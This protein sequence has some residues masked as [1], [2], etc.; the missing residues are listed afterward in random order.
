MALPWRARVFL[1]T[2]ALAAGAVLMVW[3]AAAA[4]SVAGA[5][6]GFSSRDLLALGE[7]LG[8]SVL[9]QYFHVHITPK[10]KVQLAS[11]VYFAV[12]LLYGVPLA[13]V[14]TACS[15]LIGQTVLVLRGQRGLPG[16]IFNTSQFTLAVA[17]AGLA[18]VTTPPPWSIILSAVVLYV[19]NTG[20][21]ITMAALHI[22]ANPLELWAIGRR[23]HIFHEAGLLLIGWIVA[24]TATIDLWVPLVMTIPAGIIHMSLKRHAMLVEQTV[25]A[26]EAL[27]DIVD[28]RDHYTFE[29]SKRVAGFA[30]KIARAMRLSGSEIEVIRSAARVHDLGK[31]GVPDTVLR[32]QGSLTEEEWEQMRVHSEVGYEILSRFPE[33][34][35]GRELVRSHHERWDGTGYPHGLEGDQIHLGAQIIAVADSFDAMT[36]DRPYRKA[37]SV[38]QAL[39]ELRRHKDAQWPGVIVDAL[40]RVV[41]QQQRAAAAQTQMTPAPAPA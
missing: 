12:L 31:I 24:R 38:E 28:R 8:L 11:A 40:E 34:R 2:A 26:V 4:L 5:D 1:Y 20:A 37:S 30:E 6:G 3:P 35:L 27:A 7:L 16:L 21:V 22:G 17:A 32:K 36:S 15:Q 19:V 18:Y 9:G 41:S 23:Q 14:F 39:E 25:S 33:Y 29:H 10:R 13:V